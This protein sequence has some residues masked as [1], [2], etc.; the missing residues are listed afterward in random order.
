MYLTVYANH[1]KG[2]QMATINLQFIAFLKCLLQGG[3][4][5]IEFDALQ[6]NYSSYNE[7]TVC[8]VND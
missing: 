7:G 2:V 6:V 1:I 5:L 4:V 3:E 8:L